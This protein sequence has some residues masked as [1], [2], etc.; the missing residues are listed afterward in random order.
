MKRKLVTF[1]T[2]TAMVTLFTTGINETAYAQTMDEETVVSQNYASGTVYIYTAAD[3][4]NHADTSMGDN[5]V[6]MND[7]DISAYMGN[8]AGMQLQGT[9]HIWNQWR[10]VPVF[11]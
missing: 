2:M 7:I 10:Q 11:L 1:L 5:Y 4:V 3:L 9:Y 6:L 8:I